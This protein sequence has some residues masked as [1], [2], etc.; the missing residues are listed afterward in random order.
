M[1]DSMIDELK[2]ELMQIQDVNQEE[3]FSYFIQYVDNADELKR[4]ISYGFFRFEYQRVKLYFRNTIFE[5]GISTI[6]RTFHIAMRDHSEECKPYLKEFAIN[7]ARGSA[8]VSRL[9]FLNAEE[10]PQ[11]L[12][13]FAKE[14]LRDIAEM[15]E[16]S[17]QPYMN[18]YYQMT[19]IIK[20]KVI[21]K[22]VN[23][24]IQ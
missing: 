18:M 4:M 8:N 9:R 6:V 3:I 2:T 16:N 23:W 13:L 5:E 14:V 10:R 20:G 11:R 17:I 21:I 7:I 19:R 22:S 24:K 12:D 1:Y 15:V